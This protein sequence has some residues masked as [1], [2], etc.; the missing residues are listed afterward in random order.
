SIIPLG[1]QYQQLKDSLW[2]PPSTVVGSATEIT[3][4]DTDF[5]NVP[6]AKGGTAP[7]MGFMIAYNLL[8]SSHTLRTYSQPEPQYRGFAGGLGR[9]GANRLVIFETDGVPNTRAFATFQSSSSDSY[10]P[11][12]IKFPDTLSDGSNEFP[13]GG[14]YASSEV[15]DVVDIMT[16]LESDPNP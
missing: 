9:K 8:S 11:I 6:R 10:Y 2:F 15:Y 3:P 14:T 1:R 16:N 4:Y 7:G 12:R 5:D 13:T